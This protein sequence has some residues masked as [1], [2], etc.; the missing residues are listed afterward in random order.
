M[1]I[2][3]KKK[4]L[5]FCKATSTNTVILEVLANDYIIVIDLMHCALFLTLDYEL[6]RAAKWRNARDETLFW[7]M[8]NK[9]FMFSVI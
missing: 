9:I 6:L 2:F 5:F 3:G 1:Q 4:M 8:E 7:V